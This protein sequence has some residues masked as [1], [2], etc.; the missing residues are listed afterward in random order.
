MSYLREKLRNVKALKAVYGVFYGIM[1]K[2]KM[3]RQNE[4]VRTWGID[5]IEKVQRELKDSG[6][7]TTLMYGTLL[8]IVRD[9]HLIPHDYDTDL[10]V[11]DDGQLSWDKLDAAMEALGYHSIE[12]FY[13]FD[14]FT[15]LTEVSYYKNDLKLDIFVVRA[16]DDEPGHYA[17]FYNREAGVDYPDREF[18]DRILV[19]HHEI[20]QVVPYKVGKR[21]FYV[22]LDPQKA[23]AETYGPG[24]K[25]PDPQWD[26]FDAKS[27]YRYFP[28]E[29][30]VCK[31][32][33]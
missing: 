5:E 8:G 10:G 16:F 26:A 19:V 9:G 23:L 14:D 17:Y 18:F 32:G 22:P 30:G 15:D 12:R 13:R 25:V 24:W 27:T 20:T 7:T 31:W 6:F 3:K 4:A 11:F 33:K 29:Y 1:W 2:R 21:T 28:G